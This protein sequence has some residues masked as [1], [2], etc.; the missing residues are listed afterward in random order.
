MFPLVYGLLPN[1]KQITYHRFVSHVR[2]FAAA[3]NKIISPMFVFTDFEVAAQN[4]VS[5]VFPGVTMKGCF[6]HY[7]QAVWNNVQKYGL[8]HR[9]ADDPSVTQLV[10]HAI[11]LLLEP[12]DKVSDMWLYAL[13]SSPADPS[14]ER[15]GDCV[16]TYWV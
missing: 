2:Y 15:F 10:R 14:T 1:K 5:S 8:S 9:F 7:S 12:L 3:N 6:F 11:A 13:D 4:A 16:T